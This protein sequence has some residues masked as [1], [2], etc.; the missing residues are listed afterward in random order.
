MPAGVKLPAGQGR[1]LPYFD[2][3]K[4]Y[5]VACVFSE[6]FEWLSVQNRLST[7]KLCLF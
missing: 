2:F 4:K 1:G 7:R 6:Y 5:L 3:G